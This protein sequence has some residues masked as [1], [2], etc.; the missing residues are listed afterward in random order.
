MVVYLSWFILE[1]PKIA[2]LSGERNRKKLRSNGFT[3]IYKDVMD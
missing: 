1:Q 2:K 3:A